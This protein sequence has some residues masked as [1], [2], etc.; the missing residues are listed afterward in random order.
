MSSSTVDVIIP[1]YKPEMSFYHLIEQLEQ[2]T[3]KPGKIILMNTGEA[4]LAPF[5]KKTGL[6]DKFA[7]IELHHVSPEE[8]DHGKTRHEGVGYSAAPFFLCMTQDALPADNRLIEHLL[9]ALEEPDT[10]VAYGRQLAAPDAGA[11][12]KFTRIFNYPE[13]S[14]KKSRKDLARLGIK[15]YFCSNVCAAYNRRIY[16]RLGGFIRHTI[17][18]EDMIFAAGAVQA[19]FSVVYAA[20]AAV[21]HSHHYTG[22]QQFHRNFDLGVSQADHPEVFGAVPSEK[23]GGRL[24]KETLVYLRRIKKPWLAVPFFWQCG[25]KY[26][27]YRMGKA[28]K[29]LP[30]SLVLRC[31]MNKNYWKNYW[32]S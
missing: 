30:A 2:Q 32:K 27:G 24:V 12:E 22:K 13:E 29:K 26:L 14:C 4:Y 28:Y 16:D 18:N 15:T 10:A 21:V 31:S 20:Q 17:F 19:G 9:A 3:V 7:N 6:L 23:E 11:L 1:V 5:L 8:F 25:C